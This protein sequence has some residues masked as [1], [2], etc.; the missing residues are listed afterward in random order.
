MSLFINKKE[1]NLKINSYTLNSNDPKALLLF[2]HYF[3][4][5][6]SQTL[7]EN[8]ENII[9]LCIGSDRSTGDCLGPLIGHKLYKNKYNKI[10]ILGTLENPVHAKNLEKT[11]NTIKASYPSP[12]IISL[13]A[14]LGRHNSIGNII[15]SSGP[16]KPGAGVNKNLP[17]VG[18]MS[19]IGI[20]NI[21]GYMEYS[22]LQSTRL[23]TVMKIAD[24]IS[25][26]LNRHFNLI[27]D[28]YFINPSTEKSHFDL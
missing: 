13:D 17:E 1:I 28:S 16:L 12:F 7:P 23:N 24:I 4:L 27:S 26:G 21:G 8:I 5:C 3:D 6:L 11:L 25:R 9:L 2:Y 20:V 14:C 18:D 22:I 10:H 19:I 15:I